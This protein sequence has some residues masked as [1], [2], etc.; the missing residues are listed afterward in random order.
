M[1]M[2]SDDGYFSWRKY[3]IQSFDAEISFEFF[4]E[5]RPRAIHRDDVHCTND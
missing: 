2:I 5:R 1:M 3:L 4:V